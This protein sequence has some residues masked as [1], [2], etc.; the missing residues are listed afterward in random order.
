[1][2]MWSLTD[3]NNYN[4]CPLML[5]SVGDI[6]ISS[7]YE[8]LLASQSSLT[9]SSAAPQLTYPQIPLSLPHRYLSHSHKPHPPTPHHLLLSGLVTR[10]LVN[11]GGPIA[12]VE[13]SKPVGETEQYIM[14]YEQLYFYFLQMSKQW[15]KEH[16]KSHFQSA[17]K[18]C[19]L[20]YL[21]CL[22]KYW[23]PVFQVTKNT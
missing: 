3:N 18:L 8:S 15:D 2:A 4:Y 17:T 22:T 16:S 9:S 5:T 21:K 1:M 10:F 13:F 6:S 19:T 14:W 12:V 23:L 20:R 11:I 7:V